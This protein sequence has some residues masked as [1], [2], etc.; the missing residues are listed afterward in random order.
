MFGAMFPAPP[1][2]VF[3]ETQAATTETYLRYEDITQDGRLMPIAVPPSLAGVWRGVLV[4]H[5]G[6][7]A[8]A[9]S[10]IL[11]ILTRLTIG[12]AESPIRVD[13]PIE[14]RG[15]FELAH[16][17]D[18]SGEV[19]RLFMNVWS[20]VWGQGGRIVPR[21]PAGPPTK[22]GWLFA[23]HTFT[24][25]FGPPDQRR[26]TKLNV[27]GYPELPEA[28]Y[29]APSPASAGQAPDGAIWIDEL[30]PDPA[31]YV[32][33]L[34]QTDSNQHVNSLVY[35]RIFLDAVNRRLAAIGR[36]LGQRSRA[37]DIAYRKP[38]FAGDR[39]KAH[40]RLFEHQDTLGAAGFVAVPGEEAKPRCFV[41]ITIGP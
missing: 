34:D 7:T 23:E 2:P 37:V 14:C 3:P 39:V 31:D 35:I 17:R 11:P 5:P 6:A 12:V 8:A 41:R 28:R 4:K 19:T 33:T 26:I 18:A 29:P 40:L 10:G 36:P 15:G 22:A 25:P 13:R 30:A 16:D 24:R 20:E 38:C 32:F 9:Q 27:A 21:T 1:S